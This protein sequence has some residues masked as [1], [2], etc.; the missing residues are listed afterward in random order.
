M[1]R[2]EG[3][4]ALVTGAGAGIG[5]AVAHAMA[6]EGAAVAVTDIAQDR[7]DQVVGEVE[8]AGG[9][10]IGLLL[11]ILDEESMRAGVE[12]VVDAFGG[13]DTLVNNA[14]V[15]SVG[16]DRGH[17]AGALGEPVQGE[18]DERLPDVED[19]LAAPQAKRA[20][21]RSPTPRRSPGSGRSAAT[22]PTAP[23]RR[24]C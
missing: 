11:D 5:R 10:A 4:R 12:Q 1:G 8:D 9:R 2:L 19:R 18:H 6:A 16:H 22:S 3:K 14:G 13:L 21:A 20:V 7:I 15:A 23:R 24:P 17:D